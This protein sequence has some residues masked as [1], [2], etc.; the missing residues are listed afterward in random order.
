MAQF[1]VTI[2]L[3]LFS[4]G[5]TSSWAEGIIPLWVQPRLSVYEPVVNEISEALVRVG[6]QPLLCEDTSLIP[7][8]A[9]T[10]ILVG[11]P[12]IISRLVALGDPNL[13]IPES[14]LVRRIPDSRYVIATAEG[15]RGLLYAAGELAER[16][17][18]YHEFPEI[19]PHLERPFFEIRAFG[20]EWRTQWNASLQNKKEPNEGNVYDSEA[21][22]DRFTRHLIRNR[23]NLLV[24]FYAGQV[25][26]LLVETGEQAALVARRLH[27]LVECAH[28]RQLDVALWLNPDADLDT[29][30]AVADSPTARR[31]RWSTE[32]AKLALAF[33]GVHLGLWSPNERR[34]RGIG[35]ANQWFDGF[36]Q[37]WLALADKEA[38]TFLSGVGFAPETFNDE[39]ARHI[40]LR[41]DG[42][43][44]AVVALKWCGDHPEVCLEPQFTDQAWFQQDPINYRLL[45]VLG[46]QDVRCLR[47]A[48]YHRTRQILLRM[49]KLGQAQLSAGFVFF[50]KGEELGTETLNQETVE[51]RIPWAWG[52]QKHWYRHALWGRLGYEPRR[53]LDDF[54]PMFVDGYGEAVGAA[55]IEE[56]TTGEDL[57]WRVSRFHWRHESDDWYPEACLAPG[58]SGPYGILGNRTG[59]AYQDAGQWEHPFESILEFIFSLTANPRELS[60]LEAVGYELTGVDRPL[61][62]LK[63]YT[64]LE[65]AEIL[66]RQCAYLESICYAVSAQA[67][68]R[69]VGRLEH[70][71][72]DSP[73]HFEA[74][75]MAADLVLQRL[76]GSYYRSKILAARLFTLALCQDSNAL[77]E[78][79]Q[80]ELEKGLIAWKAYVDRADRIYKFP[81]IQAGEISRWTDL[82]AP[83]EKDLEIIR[84]HSAFKKTV[85]TQPVYGPFIKGSTA[86]AEFEKRYVRGGDQ[87]P[88]AEFSFE[89]SS[90]ASEDTLEQGWLDILNHYAGFLPLGKI[91]NPASGEVVWVPLP[92]PAEV[93]DYLSLRLV[94]GTIDEVVWG[95]RTVLVS[96]PEEENNLPEKSRLAGPEGARTLWI[97]S[98]RPP[99]EWTQWNAS[100]AGGPRS[101]GTDSSSSAS[102]SGGSSVWG[103]A[104]ALEPDLPFLMQPAWWEND[105]LVVRIQNRLVIGRLDNI[106][107]EVKPVGEG[108]VVPPLSPPPISLSQERTFL[109]PC[110]LQTGWAALK[111]EAKWHREKIGL[112]F[113]PPNLGA[114]LNLLTSV[115]GA[116][117]RLQTL[118]RQPPLPSMEGRI[119]LRPPLEGT[120]SLPCIS[121]IRRG[122]QAA[123]LYRVNEAYLRQATEGVPLRNL[124]VEWLP[125]EQGSTVGVEYRSI[126]GGLLKL[127][128]ETHSTATD[129]L[130]WQVSR[131]PLPELLESPGEAGGLTLR[132]FRT[133]HRD[134]LVRK[135]SF[136]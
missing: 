31:Q 2:L 12:A 82:I 114:N 120:H 14:Y 8:G 83:A 13:R 38:S 48:S 89:V 102:G 27:N 111:L 16:I 103:F 123:L 97:C 9:T 94:G 58:S 125:E 63:R 19:N 46:D 7:A 65:T 25:R 23:Y 34:E 43:G 121:T 20:M 50:P 107:V 33:P 106:Q 112:D 132:I 37:P 113:F 74:R 95:G 104:V 62:P 60:I 129:P 61:E 40:P 36:L 101:V 80:K 24:L 130:Q 26:D 124:V 32:I 30:L 77:R 53:L 59:P 6:Y 126:Q 73:R 79:S 115:A 39:I 4:F 45:W 11:F 90:F 28:S 136:E 98:N 105:G 54:K 119:P 66:R 51:N 70:L 85:R 76:I 118:P 17:T 134:L 52:F 99:L 91:P 29:P 42:T 127:T 87:P 96:N 88:K 22:P 69:I 5:S 21:F 68:H 92:V 122:W 100:W 15:E 128:T 81:A 10:A 18:I 67:P 64:P 93:Q 44:G 108:W 131:L 41:S 84:T 47:S 55:L 35:D 57:L 1:L 133:D 135:V 116:I 75:H 71:S 49:G 109:L 78:E 72:Q 86:L 56:E 117:P 3:C 110:R